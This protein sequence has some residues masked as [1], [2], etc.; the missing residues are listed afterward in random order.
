MTDPTF[1]K[2]SARAEAK[3]RG[4]DYF[5]ITWTNHPGEWKL[6]H[7]Q[8][9]DVEPLDID[10]DTGLFDA[11]ELLREHDYDAYI[12]LFVLPLDRVNSVREVSKAAWVEYVNREV[13]VE[14]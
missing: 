2:R 5:I 6:A 12:E 13:P 14:S 3:L 7:R 9:L 8:G 4:D 11:M 1:A 10:T